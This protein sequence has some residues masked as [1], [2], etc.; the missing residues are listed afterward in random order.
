MTLTVW[1]PSLIWGRQ[2]L[3]AWLGKD[4]HRDRYEPLVTVSHAQ[5]SLPTVLRHKLQW[6]NTPTYVTAQSQN[7][8]TSL[9]TGGP[10]L[11]SHK[12]Y[13]VSY[14]PLVHIDCRTHWVSSVKRLE[15]ESHNPISCGTESAK[16]L[17][18][19]EC[20]NGLSL[21]TAFTIQPV[22]IHHIS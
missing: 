17:S 15:R 16:L 20:F 6:S 13:W 18:L 21:S 19:L 22:I 4:F 9:R 1:T 10:Q 2:M 14:S 3:L 8:L 11:N 7:R 12:G 5:S